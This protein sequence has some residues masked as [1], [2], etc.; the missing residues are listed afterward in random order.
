MNFLEKMGE[1]IMRKKEN[2]GFDKQALVR[3]RKGERERERERERESEF[4]VYFLWPTSW[5]DDVAC[6]SV[7]ENEKETLN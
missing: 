5:D 6:D 2:D 3:V 4:Q 7:R 1:M